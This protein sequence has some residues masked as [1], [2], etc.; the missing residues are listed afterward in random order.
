MLG[1]SVSLQAG[2]RLAR[3]T[4]RSRVG[5]AVARAAAPLALAGV[6]A[7]VVENVLLLRVV[8]SADP[9]TLRPLLRER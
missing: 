4:F 1:Y 6:A 3:A 5:R 9:E 8:H 7:D 2:A